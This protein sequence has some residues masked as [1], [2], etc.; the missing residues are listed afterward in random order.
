M[1]KKIT[2]KKIKEKVVLAKE[3]G[4]SLGGFFILGFPSETEEEIEETIRFAKELPLDRAA[5]FYF[6]YLP[7]TEEYNRLI[8]ERNVRLDWNLISLHNSR[9]LSDI[10]EK[11]LRRLR[12]KALLT[13]YLRPGAIWAMFRGVQSW[14]HLKYIL[15]RSVRWIRV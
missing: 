9:N 11:T 3:L 12:R 8:Q 7:G 15:K 14:G 4:F 5:F 10:P 1:K 6:Q 2:L 13:F